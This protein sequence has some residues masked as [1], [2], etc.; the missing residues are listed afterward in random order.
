MRPKDRNL[1]LTSSPSLDGLLALAV[2]M[3]L[4]AHLSGTRFT[5]SF[6]DTRRD[7]GNLVGRHS[8][9]LRGV[10]RESIS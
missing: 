8:P 4:F 3:V 10:I 1:A 7:L 2:G 5:P 9:I 6:V